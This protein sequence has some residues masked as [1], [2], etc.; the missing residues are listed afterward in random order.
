ME[1]RAKLD[2]FGIRS[3]GDLYEQNASPTFPIRTDFDACTS[4]DR[5]AV[6]NCATS[7]GHC[8]DRRDDHR[9]ERRSRCQRHPIVQG[10]AQAKAAGAISM[11][12]VFVVIGRD[13]FSSGMFAAI[14][15]KRLGAILIGEPTGN[16]PNSFGNVSLFTL[17]NS[18]LTWQVSTRLF[19]FPDFPGDAL[20]PDIPIEISS[21]DYFAERDPV[22]DAILK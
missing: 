22:L 8:D 7:G 12:Q 14:D 20:M 9:S 10:I 3:L 2:V 15:L 6:A 17:P 11:D 4:R 19:Q 18:R 5:F 21:M 1:N 16:R 13:T